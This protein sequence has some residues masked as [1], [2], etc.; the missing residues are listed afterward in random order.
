MRRAGTGS[1]SP[2]RCRRARRSGGERDLTGRG[3]RG[4]RGAEPSAES[5]AREPSG[6]ERTPRSRWSGTKVRARVPARRARTGGSGS[7]ARA[8]RSGAGGGGT[9]GASR[10]VP[11][12][13]SR[14]GGAR[15]ARSWAADRGDD[16]AAGRASGLLG[17]GYGP[18]SR[19]LLGAEGGGR[20]GRLPTC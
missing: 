12:Q 11:T 7:T 8:R 20:R 19:I 15:P 9:V 1:E 2:G 6:R 14:A 16:G 3:Q 13:V 4:G 18:R 5:A 10:P 17:G